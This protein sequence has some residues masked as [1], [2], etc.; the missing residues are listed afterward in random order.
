MRRQEVGNVFFYGHHHMLR[1]DELRIRLPSPVNV[2]EKI[3]VELVE[4]G[5][6][7]PPPPRQSGC[8]R[9]LAWS[10]MAGR[11]ELPASASWRASLRGNDPPQPPRP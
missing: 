7:A 4:A 8:G 2:Q 6:R 9:G 11:L 3:G 10:S 1:G 5:P